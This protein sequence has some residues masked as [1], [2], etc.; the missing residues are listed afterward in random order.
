MLEGKAVMGD[1]DMKQTMKEDALS[2]AS[3]ALDC[4]DVTEPTQIARFIK[5]EFDRSYGSGWQCIVGTHFGSFVTHCSGCFIHFSV[6]SLTILLFKGSIGEPAPR[7][8]SLAN[9][10]S[11]VK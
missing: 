1:T 4:F 3:K 11:I 7:T 8:D 10:D 2:L 9:L 5:K 6:G